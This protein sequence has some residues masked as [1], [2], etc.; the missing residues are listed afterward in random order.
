M[1]SLPETIHFEGIAGAGKS[2]ASER[3]CTLLRE[4][5]VDASWWLE[6]STD[7][8]ILPAETRALN[9][10]A[11]YPEICL[12]A[13]RSFLSSQNNSVAILDGYA[14][15]STV[16]FLFEQRVGRGQIDRY[17]E[18]WQELAPETLLTYFVV[19]D[20]A[21]H[22]EEVCTERGE[23]WTNKLYAWVE[24]TPMGTAASLRGRSGLVEFWSVYQDLCVALL[25]S[26]QIAVHI[27]AARSWRD[28]DLLNLAVS[29][30]VLPRG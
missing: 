12:D 18:R 20:P 7:H 5:G 24:R 17:F 1:I 16:R 23:D 4:R 25:D 22:F 13:W 2:S 10:R 27:V 8:P 11:D 15:Q 26:A 21:R 6:E 9:K 29:R 19:T 3:L 14:F 30:G 28:A